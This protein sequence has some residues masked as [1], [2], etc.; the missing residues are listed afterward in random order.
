MNFLLLQSSRASE[1]RI[2]P[3]LRVEKKMWKTLVFRSNRSYKTLLFLW[4][5]I[6]PVEYCSSF[7]WTLEGTLGA[8]YEEIRYGQ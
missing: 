1:K 5:K 4:T 7:P 2:G 3:K 8:Q 6:D